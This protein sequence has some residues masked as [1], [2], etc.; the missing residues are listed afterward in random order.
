MSIRERLEKAL[1][2]EPVEKPV[3]VVYDWFVENRDIDWQGLF[4][5]GLGQINHANLIEEERPHVEIIETQSEQGG[6]IR[7]DVRWVTDVGELHEWRLDGWR[8]E[9]FIKTPEDYRILAYALS[10]ST[11]TPTDQY[12]NESEAKLQDR[13]I[14]IGQLGPMAPEARTPFQTI[15]IDYA[16]LEQF[17]IDL[18]CRHIWHQPHHLYA[19]GH[20]HSRAYDTR[21]ENSRGN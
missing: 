15:Q 7:R 21:R 11:F 5:Q 16:G 3:Y 17:S 4:D 12:F 8:Q 2:N 13:G 18:P 19:P 6:K 14:T 1:A 10:E 9:Y 20:H